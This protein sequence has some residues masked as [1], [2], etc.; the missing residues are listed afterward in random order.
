MRVP[1]R[2]DV[3]DPWSATP[4]SKSGRPL[5]SAAMLVGVPSDRVLGL[6]PKQIKLD[7]RADSTPDLPI[8]HAEA[9][10]KALL[11]DPNFAAIFEARVA[12]NFI[13]Q[14]CH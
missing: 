10:S 14:I 5:I 13:G 8:L 11:S 1:L 7:E 9:K 4:G 6:N 2:S 3:N 12:G